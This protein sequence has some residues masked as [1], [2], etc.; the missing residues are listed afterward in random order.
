MLGPN[1]AGKTTTIRMLTTLI[2][3]TSGSATVAGHDVVAESAQVR[4]LIGYVGQGNGAGHTQR[5]ADEL[6]TQG[7]IYGLDGRGRGRGPASCSRRSTW[8]S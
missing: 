4:R 1:G 5:A 3:P 2:A 8:S 7:V 6:R